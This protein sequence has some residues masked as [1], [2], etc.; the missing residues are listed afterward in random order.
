V[1]VFL[2]ERLTQLQRSL[3]DSITLTHRHAVGVAVGLHRCPRGNPIM[4]LFTHNSLVRGGDDRLEGR[5][6]QYDNQP[7]GSEGRICPVQ[8][9]EAKHRV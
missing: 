1:D 9:R 2:D 5:Q 4:L 6:N 8:P 3:C 7:L